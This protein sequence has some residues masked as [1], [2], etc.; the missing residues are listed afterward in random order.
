[1]MVTVVAFAQNAAAW[2]ALEKPLNFYLAND[3]GRNG[4]Y[5]Q[6]PIAELMGKMAEAI[7]IEFV[8]AAGDV[9]HFEGV[10][11]VHDP[12]WMTN[13]ELIYSHPDLM[14]PW[15]PILGN[16]EYRGNTQAVIDYSGIS[17]RWQMPARYYTKVMEEDGATIRLVMIDTPPLLDKYRKDTEKYPDASK[18]DIDKQLVWL[19]SVLTS[20]K[21]DWV[22]VVGHH[23]IY[24]DTD[25]NESER[26]DMQKRV[27]SILRKHG[28]VDMYV[29]GHIHNF[30]HLRK[31][32]SQI[33]YVVNT[34]GSLAREVKPIDGT[35]FCSNAT[36]FSL[37][38]VDKKE[39]CL[40]MMDKEG[41]VLH[42]VRRTK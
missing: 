41:K 16:H 26:A 40:Y 14:L 15:Y 10:R 8:V 4:Y 11:S 12:L 39:L 17:A 27:D 38:T 30:Q 6:K 13:Y 9:H 37:I 42:T 24:A 20:A 33:D 3:L 35:Q 29:C 36:G 34:S 32:D 18:Q 5:D 2:K 22:I 25:K 23:P 19:D 31:P 1:M 7:D 28:N 21:E